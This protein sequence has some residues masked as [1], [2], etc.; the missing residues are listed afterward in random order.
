MLIP[1][2]TLVQDTFT[3]DCVFWSEA[4]LQHIAKP[5]DDINL[6]AFIREH[7]AVSFRGF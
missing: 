2:T 1:Q 6:A 7:A 5:V 3:V 4:I